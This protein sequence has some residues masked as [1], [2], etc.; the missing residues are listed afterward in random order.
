MVVLAVGAHPDDLELKC[1]GTL[2]KYVKQGHTVVVCTVA[3]GSL[4]DYSIKPEE[5]AEIR[6]KEA[7]AAAEKIGAT[8]IG[9]NINDLQVDGHSEYQ[10]KK[11]AELIRQVK[12]D[13][14]ITHSPDDYM[15][16]HVETSH[17]VFFSSFASS[18]PNYET[19]TPFYVA[20]QAETD[21]PPGTLF[22]AYALESLGFR[23]LIVTDEF[24]RGYFEET[25]VPVYYFDPSV[26]DRELDAF[27]RELQPVGL[28]SVER[29]GRNYSGEYMNMSGDNISEYTAPLDRLF[30]LTNE[31]TV[32]IG[33][34]G[35][36]IGMGNVANTIKEELTVSPSCVTVD[37]LIVATVSNWGALGLSMELG[38][39]PT[40]MEYLN[41]Y[42]L[43]KRLGFVDGISKQCD[44]SEDGFPIHIAQSIFDIT[45]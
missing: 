18:I 32:G 10:Q 3:N 6:K 24:C 7:T 20:G 14:I 41:A 5:L 40:Q 33:D 31:P 36:E 21:G 9:L 19:Q 42:A 29:C 1:F 8:Y 35:N 45:I 2:A 13:V 11:M 38:H 26:T 30:L 17:L 16:D 43:C 23:P 39:E 4:G 34:G 15:S 44:L 22:L 27:L 12:P 28:I 37:H 25:D